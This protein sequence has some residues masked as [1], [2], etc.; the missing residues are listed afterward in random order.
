MNIEEAKKVLNIENFDYETLRK[1]YK[2]KALLYHPDKIGGNKEEFCKIKEAYDVLL[3]NVNNKD[4]NI[5]DF[6]RDH[7]SNITV[8]QISEIYYLFNDGDTM[9]IVTRI[10]NFVIENR[11]YIKMSDYILDFLNKI[12]EKRIIKTLILQP[13][14]DD[15]LDHN[16]YILEIKNK[17]I[18]IPLWHEELI[19]EIDNEIYMIKIIPNLPDNVEI[20]NDDLVFYLQY[21][22]YQIW[23]NDK[24]YFHNSLYFKRESLKLKYMQKITL[25]N[26]GISKINKQH[27]YNIHKKGNIILNIEL[28]M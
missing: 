15:L 28:I 4:S 2:E 1:V 3:T 24:I 18:K 27:I 12:Q 25:Y 11:K 16:L 22:I 19:Y 6:L 20:I 23:K 13:N 8:K 5:F 17:K 26:E 10:Y 14:L 7:F 21:N 9:E